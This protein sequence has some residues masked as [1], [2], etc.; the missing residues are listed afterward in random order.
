MFSASQSAPGPHASWNNR[1]PSSIAVSRSCSAASTSPRWIRALSRPVWA[2]SIRLAS[3]DR[4]TTRS[5]RNSSTGLRGCQLSFQ[6]LDSSWYWPKS[7][8]GKTRILARQPWSRAFILDRF[9]PSSVR[10]PVLRWLFLQFASICAAVARPLA[11]FD[12][13]KKGLKM[14]RFRA[15]G[16]PRS[17]Y[18]LDKQ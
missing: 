4:F 13:S 11:P 8:V 10:G 6:A 9:L 16:E 7:S 5:T 18:R 17:L 1:C 2:R 12:E 14:N 15:S 3:H